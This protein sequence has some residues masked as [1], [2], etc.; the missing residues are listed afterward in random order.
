MLFA[1]VLAAI[2]VQRPKIAHT[3]FDASL[4]LFVIAVPSSDRVHDATGERPAERVITWP[5][6]T[7][8]NL[9]WQ[10]TAF[11]KA[12]FQY[13]FRFDGYHKDTTTSDEFQVPSSTTTN[14]I[15]GAYEYR[16]AG[17]SFVANGA[18]FRRAGW[19]PWGLPIRQRR[20]A[21]RTAATYVCS[22]QR[23]LS[24]DVYLGLFQKLHFNGG[25]L[26]RRTP[27]PLQ[28]L[29]VRAVRRHAHSRRAGIGLRFDD[30]AMVRGSYRSTFSNSTESICSSNA[31]PAAMRDASPDW[32]SLTGTGI[33]LNVRAPFGY[34]P[35]RRYRP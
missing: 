1:G 28:P 5:E 19:K 33:A 35:S 29:P 7:G 27:R 4:D 16:R 15:G 10:S 9:G 8:L 23:S 6:T 21:T 32:Q 3:P 17:Y 18:W 26:R 11:Q 2:N 25:V 12:T 22:L 34:D 14:G 31:P 30:L 13:Q 24:R 20:A